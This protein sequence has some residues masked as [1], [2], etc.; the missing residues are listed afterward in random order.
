MYSLGGDS[1]SIKFNCT[2]RYFNGDKES[3]IKDRSGGTVLKEI[4]IEI[5]P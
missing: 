1:S 2:P 5:K 4:S 3:I